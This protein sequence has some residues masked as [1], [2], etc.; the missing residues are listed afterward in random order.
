MSAKD[1]T[2]EQLA[3]GVFLI[4]IAAVVGWIVASFVFVILRHP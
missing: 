1:Y 4:S 3:R 2:G